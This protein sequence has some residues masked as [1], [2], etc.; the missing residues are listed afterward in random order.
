MELRLAQLAV[1]VFERPLSFRP[2]AALAAAHD[3]REIQAGH[4]RRGLG[5]GDGFFAVRGGQAFAQRQRQDAA[6]LRAAAAQ[7]AREAPRVEVGDGHRAFALQVVGERERAAEVGGA[8]RQVLDD[9]AGGMDLLGLDVFLVDAVAADVR[10]RQ[11]DDLPAV[12][13]VGEDLLVAGQRGVE[14]HLADGA[15]GRADRD[16][17]EDRAVCESQEGLGLWGQQL[18]RHRDLRSSVRAQLGSSKPKPA[19][20]KTAPAGKPRGNSVGISERFAGRG[21]RS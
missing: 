17:V 9:Q 1:A 5:G 10:I 13:R 6:V 16:P 4:A 2:V 8:D 18:R 15:T 20:A 14:H 21:G 12:A 19:F 3:L 11:R 7:D